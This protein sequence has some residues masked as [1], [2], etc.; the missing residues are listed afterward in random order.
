MPLELLL[1]WWNLIYILPFGLALLYLGLFVFTGITFGDA[2]ADA[3]LDGDAQLH[4]EA[5]VADMDSDAGVEMDH[6]VTRGS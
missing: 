2:D 6:A 5:H 1:A 3:D 4:V